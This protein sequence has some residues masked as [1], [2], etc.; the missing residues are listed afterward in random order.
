MSIRPLTIAA[1]VLV[2]AALAACGLFNFGK[3]VKDCTGAASCSVEVAVKDCVPTTAD[4]I[5]VDKSGPPVEIRWQA[6][7]GYAFTREG[8]VFEATPVVID[9]KPGIQREGAS[10]AVVDRPNGQKATAK[11]RLQLRTTAGPAAVCTGPDPVIV[12]E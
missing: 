8:I 3:V 6:P 11:Y 10:W 7:A 9:S 12:N 1:M 2:P 4:V 5:R